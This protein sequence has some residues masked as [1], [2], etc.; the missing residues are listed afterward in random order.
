MRK[1]PSNWLAGTVYSLTAVLGVMTLFFPSPTIEGV[2][3][4][5]MIYVYGSLLVVG[6][7]GALIGIMRPN[8][9]IEMNFLWGISTGYGVYAIALWSVGLERLLDTS[10]YPPPFGPA[11]A[12][13]VLSILVTMRLLRLYRLNK[14]LLRASDNDRLG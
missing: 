11:F 12:V 4:V 8:Y 14:E 7:V 6:S 2:L 9:M 5:A 13:T 10:I 3:G 1:A